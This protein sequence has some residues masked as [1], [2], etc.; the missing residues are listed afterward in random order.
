MTKVDLQKLN[1]NIISRVKF[2]H[3]FRISSN[4][5]FYIYTDE[6]VK[7]IENITDDENEVSSH[8]LSIIGSSKNDSEDI[9]ISTS[10]ENLYNL[11][12]HFQRIILSHGIRQ[13]QK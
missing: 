2:N 1:D 4:D 13:S 7:K 8:L 9:L 6:L 5:T 10:P 12:V 3:D 11:L